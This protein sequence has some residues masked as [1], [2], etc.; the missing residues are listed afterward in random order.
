VSNNLISNANAIMRDISLNGNIVVNGLSTNRGKTYLVGDTSINKLFVNDIAQFNQ[1]L[2]ASADVS[3]NTNANIGGN[4]NTQGRL[5]VVGDTSLNVLYV[6]NRSYLNSMLTVAGDASFTTL[7]TTQTAKLNA[8][9]IAKEATLNGNILTTDRAYIGQNYYQFKNTTQ[10]FPMPTYDMTNTV[11]DTY[12]TITYWV[13]L[14]S[15]LTGNNNPI[16]TLNGSN[17][18]ETRTG[19]L[20]VVSS[21][22]TVSFNPVPL[23]FGI[24]HLHALVL[25]VS[26]TSLA[27][28]SNYLIY[29]NNSASTVATFQNTV[30]MV[31]NDTNTFSFGPMTQTNL[32]ADMRIRDFR[33]YNRQ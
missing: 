8:V 22:S 24:F 7:N 29:I 10:T 16:I 13:Q 23:G 25:P 18:L 32:G 6:A 5:N 31:I 28:N 12:I 14:K 21:K 33:I 20:W 19:G 1:P 11:K 15:N 27:T 4:I 30:S 2:I 9:E 26:T 17:L 3:L